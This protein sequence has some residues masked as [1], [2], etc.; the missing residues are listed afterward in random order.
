MILLICCIDNSTHHGCATLWNFKQ[1][2]EDKLALN[3]YLTHL[4][5]YFPPISDLFIT[6]FKNDGS[7]TSLQDLTRCISL[8]SFLRKNRSRIYRKGR[9]SQYCMIIGNVDM[10]C[11]NH[12]LYVN[13][14][15]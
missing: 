12:E 7:R 11:H 1:L 2:Y 14:H 5:T 3:M 13:H 6:I 15:F 8:F 9:I 10:K 4:M